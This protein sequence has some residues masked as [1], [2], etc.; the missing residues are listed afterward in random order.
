[1][2]YCGDVSDHSTQGAVSSTSHTQTR[3][4]TASQKY[5]DCEICLTRQLSSVSTYYIY[6]WYAE[7]PTAWSCWLIIGSVAIS[8][9]GFVL[10]DLNEYDNWLSHV[11][12]RWRGWS[13][14]TSSVAPAGWNIWLQRS[15]MKAWDRRSPAPH[16]SVTSW[17]MMS[18]SCKYVYQAHRPIH[19]CTHVRFVHNTS[20]DLC[21]WIFFDS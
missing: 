9:I 18:Q 19:M 21:H 16:T 11:Y 14:G 15:C 1:M 8:M 4:T 10:D 12:R 13:A 5:S 7:Y 17:W 3:S 2:N 20:T 6:Q